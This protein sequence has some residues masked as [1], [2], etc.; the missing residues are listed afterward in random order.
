MG[1]WNTRH[2]YRETLRYD[3][4]IV[5]LKLIIALIYFYLMLQLWRACCLCMVKG[6]TRHKHGKT[7][8]QELGNVGL[9]LFVG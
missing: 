2:K 8:M 7:L 9:Q 3:L 1:K 5:P 6:K 4:D